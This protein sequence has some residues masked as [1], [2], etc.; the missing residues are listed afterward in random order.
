MLFISGLFFLCACAGND[1]SGMTDGNNIPSEGDRDK[2]VL[3]GTSALSG[4]LT[5]ALDAFPNQGSVGILASLYDPSNTDNNGNV[6]INWLSYA[7]IV[8]APA[9][10]LVRSS[11]DT[12]Y[13]FDWVTDDSRPK[14]WPFDGSQLVFM[15]Y[16]PHTKDYP[17]N[18]QLDTYTL[19]EL[20]FSFSPVS[21]DT[22]DVMFAS[23]NASH[24][25]YS[26]DPITE[27]N[28]TY[29]SPTV[30]LGEF[31][32]ALSQLTVEVVSDEGMNPNIVI[33]ELTVETT[34]R[35]ATISLADGSVLLGEPGEIP[36]VYTLIS[37]DTPFNTEAF[38]RT[39][40]LIPGT[41]DVTKISISLRDAGSETDITYDWSFMMPFFTNI[42]PS[43]TET[44]KLEQGMNSTARIRV[45]SVGVPTPTEE[46]E[47]RGVISGWNERGKFGVTIN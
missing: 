42:D 37:S 23:N 10:A 4:T 30:D 15:A 39:V 6:I 32:H 3:T 46:I 34:H 38:S 29:V 12:S 45:K 13:S 14:Y 43:S 5:R 47:L 9:T 11:G 17:F 7:D 28:G 19:S 1:D 18:L 20:F 36:Y 22:P 41:E 44:L 25:P 33:T 16:S 31:R 26:K 27:S 24:T 8:N 21:Q 40:L 35:S 2:I